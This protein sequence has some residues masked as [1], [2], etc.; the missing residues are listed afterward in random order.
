VDSDVGYL[1]EI[2][3]VFKGKQVEPLEIMWSKLTQASPMKFSINS[4]V[5]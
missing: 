5:Y 4:R 2:D 1:F 3:A